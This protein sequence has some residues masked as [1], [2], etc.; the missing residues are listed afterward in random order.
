MG[1][2][3]P[4]V[5]A[6]KNT[7]E[8]DEGATRGSHVR[9]SMAWWIAATT[10]LDIVNPVD[11]DGGDRTANMSVCA[12]ILP[13]VTGAPVVALAPPALTRWPSRSPPVVAKHS[14]CSAWRA[15]RVTTWPHL[16]P[17]RQAPMTAWLARREAGRRSA[18][19]PH[20]TYRAPKAMCAPGVS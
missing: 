5:R 20:A 8:C 10:A 18:M 17:P 11:R 14:C 9:R 13:L 2:K 1:F 16:Q 4:A 15:A 6:R 3:A 7:Q 12:L 19:P